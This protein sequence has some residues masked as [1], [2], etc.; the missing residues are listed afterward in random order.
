M[1]RTNPTARMAAPSSFLRTRHSALGLQP[2]ASQPVIFA[3]ANPTAPAPNE[4]TDSNARNYRPRK[5][6]HLQP[7][8]FK[9]PHANM[10]RCRAAS[11]P[12]VSP[13]RLAPPPH[14]WPLSPQWQN[15]ATRPLERR[16]SHLKPQGRQRSHR[17]APSGPENPARLPTPRPSFRRTSRSARPKPKPAAPLCDFVP[18]CLCLFVPHGGS[19]GNHEL[20]GPH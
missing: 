14:A 15:E 1:R 20:S 7:R 10:S 11:L 16:I 8:P 13:P 9:F 6:L 19:G 2:S 12:G 18:M 5:A 4:P 17:P 3:R